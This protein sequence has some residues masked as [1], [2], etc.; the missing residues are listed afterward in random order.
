MR[1]LDGRNGE[2]W[3]LFCRGWTQERLAEQFEISQQRVSQIVRNVRDSITIE[4]RIDIVKQ[5]TDLLDQLRAEVLELWDAKPSPM[6][7]A[8]G[9]IVTTEEGHKIDDHSGRLAALAAFDRLTARK[10]RMLGL[11]APQ[12]LDLNLPGEEEAARA[13][14]AEAIAKLHGGTE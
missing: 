4:E 14:A 7:G 3:R 11:D 5:E 10:H 13:A 2:I 9:R 8:N 12:K 1:R 6:V